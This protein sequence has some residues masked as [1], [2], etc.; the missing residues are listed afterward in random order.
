MVAMRSSPRPVSDSREM[1]VPLAAACFGAA[2]AARVGD[3]RGKDGGPVNE[4]MVRSVRKRQPAAAARA[5]GSSRARAARRAARRAMALAV[6]GGQGLGG[7]A[8]GDGE[9]TVRRSW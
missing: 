6:W 5:A 7:G 2:A 9:G 1:P 8:G 3:V 4:P